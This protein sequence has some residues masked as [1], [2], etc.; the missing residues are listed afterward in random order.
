MVQEIDFFLKKRN[1][2]SIEI[3]QLEIEKNNLSTNKSNNARLSEITAEIYGKQL[4]IEF[5]TRQISIVFNHLKATEV[6]QNRFCFLHVPLSLTTEEWTTYLAEKGMEHWLT[7]N[8]KTIK[9]SN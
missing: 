6:N 2:L 1:L 8:A 3:E 7:Q 9:N 4:S 5:F